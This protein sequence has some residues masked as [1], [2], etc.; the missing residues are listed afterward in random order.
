MAI[1]GKE[2]NSEK[3]FDSDF[4]TAKEIRSSLSM[5]ESGNLSHQELVQAVEELKSNECLRITRRILPEVLE[6]RIYQGMYRKEN[7]TAYN[8]W[9]YGDRIRIRDSE[10][11]A[12]WSI[13]KAKEEWFNLH[14]HTVRVLEKIID[15]K[16]QN[17]I[18]TGFHIITPDYRPL[19]RPLIFNIRGRSYAWFL[20]HHPEKAQE[21]FQGLK[22]DLKDYGDRSLMRIPSRTEH[23]LP[24]RDYTDYTLHGVRI[25]GLPV[26][27]ETKFVSPV[28]IDILCDCEWSI[29]NQGIHKRWTK[30][31]QLFC[32]HAVAAIELDEP[33]RKETSAKVRDATITYRKIEE[34]IESAKEEDK[35][36]LIIKKENLEAFI[37]ANS[38]SIPLL[39]DLI[40]KPGKSLVYFNDVLDRK[41]TIKYQ[42][43]ERNLNE[44][45]REILLNKKMFIEIEKEGYTK[46][47]NSNPGDYLVNFLNDPFNF[48]YNSLQESNTSSLQDKINA[49][50]GPE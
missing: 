45:E 19:Y 41:V 44:I 5:R 31:E 33:Y 35:E 24:G 49:L 2:E 48:S 4:P 47:L 1:I 3:W 10:G 14:I 37:E 42:G 39:N 12:R 28:R 38:G 36:A 15:R 18:W 46:T 32:T 30:P 17:K 43:T 21:K 23:K 11:N 26:D 27:E 34:Q 29:F 9:R 22:Y 7:P 50:Y 20:K 25:I 16:Q 40:Y 13:G 8:V 6:T